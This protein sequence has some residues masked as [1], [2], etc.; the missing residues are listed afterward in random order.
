MNFDFLKGKK[1]VVFGLGKA[2]LSAVQKLS[3]CDVKI[4]AADDSVDAMQKLNARNLPNVSVTAISDI[5]WKEVQYLLLSPGVPFTHP[6]PHEVVKL[7]QKVGCPIVCDVEFLYKANKD[8]KFIGITGT[9]GKSTTT[10]LIGHVMKQSGLKVTVG[11]N[12]GIPV[13]DLESLDEDGFYVV[14][15]SSYQLDLIDE[16]KFTI[17]VWLNITPDHIDRHGD[18]AGY[19]KAK[20]HIFAHQKKNEVAIIGVDEEHSKK[21]YED[22]K[23]DKVIGNIIP[24]SVEH[25]LPYGVSMI[26]GVIYDNISDKKIIKLEELKYLRGKHNAQNIAAAYVAVKFAGVTENNFVESL[27]S[28]KG[29]PHRMQYI[30]NK[31]GIIY[32][33]DS[34]ATNAEAASKALDTY[35]NIYWLAGGVQKEGGIESLRKFFPKIKHAFL[36]GQARDEFAQTMKGYVEYSIFSNMEEAFKAARSL[37]TKDNT[38]DPVILLSPACASFDQWQNF[39][40]RGEAFAK[41]V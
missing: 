17:S 37:A 22:L 20:K 27:T 8:A 39:E 21:L 7:A 12:I 16:M 34:K 38:K 6:Q 24:I 26:N 28:F 5:N 4:I 30:A 14:E 2:G 9:N 15:M 32:V 25:I 29:M 31:N 18:I 19:I 13:L 40:A 10:S 36:F 23:K 1:I 35:D 3:L 41:L 33:N 11:G